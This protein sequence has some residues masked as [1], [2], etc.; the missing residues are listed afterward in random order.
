[1]YTI[2]RF[3]CKHCGLSVDYDTGV[4]PPPGTRPVSYVDHE[5]Y[6]HFRRLKE[7]ESA[8]L[9]EKTKPN[10][11]KIWK[12]S[13]QIVVPPWVG[14]T[15]SYILLAKDLLQHGELLSGLNWRDFEKLIGDL[16]EFDG[17]LVQVTQATRDGGIDVVAIKSDPVLGKIKSIW[18]AKKYG[19][20]NKVKL[21][22]VRELSAIREYEKA[23]KAIIVTTSHL[24]HDAIEWVKQDIFRLGY[25]DKEDL[26]K[27]L[28]E[29]PT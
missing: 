23:T 17:W 4:F 10:E 5:T 12:P 28:Q 21:S 14:T 29:Y 7:R 13:D 18:Q 2:H 9:L 19:Q 15:P 8:A 20:H 6:L 26:K 22:E 27:W 16:L 25:K 3:E 1:M 11:P 24:T